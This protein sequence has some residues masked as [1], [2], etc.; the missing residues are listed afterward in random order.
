MTTSLSNKLPL[1]AIGW[2]VI[3]LDWRNWQPVTGQTPL[4]RPLRRFT[5]S[6]PPTAPNLGDGGYI[7][8]GYVQCCIRTRPVVA[9]PWKVKRDIAWP[10]DLEVR[11]RKVDQHKC[12]GDLIAGRHSQS[13]QNDSP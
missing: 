2:L 7:G 4:R 1:V 9:A 6:L 5:T 10:G 8:A 13:A 3:S 12:Q 11:Q